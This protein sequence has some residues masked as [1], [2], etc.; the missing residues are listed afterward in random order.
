LI[1]RRV[2]L[3]ALSVG[4]DPQMWEEFLIKR[5]ATVLNVKVFHDV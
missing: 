4:A 2:G 3:S 5:G 1:F